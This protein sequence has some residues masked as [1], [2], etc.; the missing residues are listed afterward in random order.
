MMLNFVLPAQTGL[1]DPDPVSS[2]S[3]ELHG[4]KPNEIRWLLDKV[5]GL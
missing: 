1:E 5:V 4:S 2:G 3:K